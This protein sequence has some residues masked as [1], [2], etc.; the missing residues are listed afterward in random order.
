VWTSNRAWGGE[1]KKVKGG[2]TKREQRM[3]CMIVG[4]NRQRVSKASQKDQFESR[5]ESKQ[6]VK[7]C[8]V[9]KASKKK[10]PEEKRVNNG[11]N[12]KS[13][14]GCQKKIEKKK[15]KK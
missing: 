11:E 13:G 5:G 14:D 2:K 6:R 7:K 15:K 3:K 12:K 9:S 10:T 8:I 4:G 1:H